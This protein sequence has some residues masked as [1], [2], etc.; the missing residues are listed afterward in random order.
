MLSYQQPFKFANIFSQP[1]RGEL[2]KAFISSLQDQAISFLTQDTVNQRQNV[3]KLNDIFIAEDV[4]NIFFK[5]FLKNPDDPI[6]N[7][8]DQLSESLYPL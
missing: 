3:R 5:T 2:K 7:H 6:D 8:E 1:P 4:E